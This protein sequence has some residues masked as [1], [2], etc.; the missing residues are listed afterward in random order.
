M[1]MQQVAYVG[2]GCVGQWMLGIIGYYVLYACPMH[3]PYAIP[4]VAPAQHPYEPASQV[5]Q[6]GVLAYLTSTVLYYTILFDAPPIPS[7]CP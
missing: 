3:K 5:S 2:F 7:C 1:M 4:Y 6:Q